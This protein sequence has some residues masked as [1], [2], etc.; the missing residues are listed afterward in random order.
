[1][2]SDTQVR[3]VYPLIRLRVWRLRHVGRVKHVGFQRPAWRV[4]RRSHRPIARVDVKV[5]G[6]AAA[7]MNPHIY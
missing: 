2:P 3:P 5:M 4:S 1:M 7:A 6:G